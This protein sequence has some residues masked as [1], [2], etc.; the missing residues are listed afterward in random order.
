MK[1]FPGDTR[2]LTQMGL[3]SPALRPSGLQ[4]GAV[5]KVCSKHYPALF[6]FSLV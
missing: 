1:P 4:P 3:S 2:S 6:E 5:I